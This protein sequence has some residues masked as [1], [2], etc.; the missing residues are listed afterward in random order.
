[1]QA[2]IINNCSNLNNDLY[3]NHLCDSPTCRCGFI[4]EDADHFFFNCLNYMN[5]HVTL[6]N[7]IRNYFPLNT[8][9]LLFGND[10]LTD[11]ENSSI[12]IAVQTYIKNNGRFAA[13]N[14]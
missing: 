5:E 14:H 13:V 10:S 1:M 4:I 6:Y 3:L 8:E 11:Q 2:R 9:K 7:E 12:F